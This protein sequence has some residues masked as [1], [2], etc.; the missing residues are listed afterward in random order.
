MKVQELF[1]LKD[2]VIIVTGGSKGL[3]LMMAEGL[4]EAGA[5]LVLCARNQEECEQAADQIREIGGKTLALRCDVIDQDEVNALVKQ[6]VSEFGRVDVMINNAGYV[7]EAPLEEVSLEKWNQTMA[8]NATGTFL[9][10]QAAG[11]YMIEKGGGKIINISSI[12]GLGSVD[13]EL[14]DAVP[15]AAS[16]G[17]IVSMTRDLARKWSKYN[18]NV[19]AIAP[20]Y[21]ATKMSKYVVE[22]RGPQLMASVPMRRLG[23]K[24][25]IKG[26]AVFLSSAASDFITGQVIAVDGGAVA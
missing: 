24:D 16:K 3:G 11:R 9:C 18:I 15:Y 21:F 17:A 8:I 26:V 25:E 14:S 10:S 12:I 13:P 20:G 7:W 5:N 23:E 22:H 1:S 4:A 6:T 2:K 19:N